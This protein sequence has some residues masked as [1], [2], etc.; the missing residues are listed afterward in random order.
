MG[1]AYL[2]FNSLHTCVGVEKELLRSNGPSY[3]T[4]LFNFDD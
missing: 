3:L 4:K 2:M 1:L